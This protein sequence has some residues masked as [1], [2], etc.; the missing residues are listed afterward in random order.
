[1]WTEH[2]LPDEIPAKQLVQLVVALQQEE[3]IAWHAHYDPLNADYQKRV[4]SGE[5]KGKALAEWYY[6][7]YVNHLPSE[8]EF[9]LFVAAMRRHKNWEGA[10]MG[11][12]NLPEEL[13]SKQLNSK[14]S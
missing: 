9:V 13:R 5:L 11:W 2:A 8:G 1:M 6:Q 10:L 4:A 12:A 14:F 7:R 3:R